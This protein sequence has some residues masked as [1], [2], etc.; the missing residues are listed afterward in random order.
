MKSIVPLVSVRVKYS[1]MLK[2]VSNSAVG[3]GGT[4]Q[5]SSCTADE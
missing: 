3:L 5:L 2:P 4:L 1:S